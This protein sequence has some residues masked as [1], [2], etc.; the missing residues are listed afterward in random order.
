MTIANVIIENM[1]LM[2]LYNNGKMTSSELNLSATEQWQHISNCLSQINRPE[3]AEHF[4][5][6]WFESKNVKIKSEN[7]AKACDELSQVL[8][9]NIKDITDSIK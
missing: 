4:K 3:L 5:T 9:Q 7:A 6:G 2:N 1:A 8:S